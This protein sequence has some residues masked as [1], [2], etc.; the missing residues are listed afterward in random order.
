MST[1]PSEFTAGDRITWQEEEAPEGTTAITAY[2]RTNAANGLMLLGVAT[3][4][5]CVWDFEISSASSA[6]MQPQAWQAQIVATVGADTYTVR[7]T[8]FPVLPSLAFTGTAEAI[9]LR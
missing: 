2:L 8:S 4:D 3:D 9:D 1:I 7:T 6:T 5:P